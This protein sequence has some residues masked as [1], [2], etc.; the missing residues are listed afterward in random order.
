[1]VSSPSEENGVDDGLEVQN[2][3]DRNQLRDSAEP[4]DEWEDYVFD[5]LPDKS[6]PEE[7]PAMFLA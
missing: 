7:S 2:Q 1:L 4:R 5:D 3:E 6:Y